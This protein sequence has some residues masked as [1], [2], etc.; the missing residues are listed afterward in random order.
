MLRKEMKN[1]LTW[2]HISRQLVNLVESGQFPSVLV[3]LLFTTSKFK[4]I[5]QKAQFF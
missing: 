1:E 2:H 4:G 5:Y 3:V